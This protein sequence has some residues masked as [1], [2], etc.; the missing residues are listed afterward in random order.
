MKIIG[1]R[2]S[3]TSLRY[4]ILE[5]DNGKVQFLN[6]NQ[7]HCIKYPKEIEASS[8]KLDWLYDEVCRILRKHPDTDLVAIKTNEYGRA[9]KKSTRFTSHA[10]AVT[11]LACAKNNKDVVDYIYSQLPTSSA[12]VK[13]YSENLAGKSDKYWDAQIA[14]AIVAA[15]TARRVVSG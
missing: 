4:A 3:T 15:Y 5:I 2:N 7:E 11:M 10:D 12:K 9:E 8:G 14:D 13:E 6:A 1:F